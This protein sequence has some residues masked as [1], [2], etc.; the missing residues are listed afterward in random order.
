MP[1]FFRSQYIVPDTIHSISFSSVSHSIRQS[2][3][4]NRGICSDLW[5]SEGSAG[6]KKDVAIEGAYEE[7]RVVIVDFEESWGGLMRSFEKVCGIILCEKRLEANRFGEGRCIMMKEVKLELGDALARG[8]GRVRHSRWRLI[9][10]LY[11]LRRSFSS[12]I[13][14]IV[15]L[16]TVSHQLNRLSYP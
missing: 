15:Y 8:I 10:V 2:G 11:L 14:Y 5:D 13:S 12:C 9:I 7:G 6:E 4:D 3:F 1:P 16:S